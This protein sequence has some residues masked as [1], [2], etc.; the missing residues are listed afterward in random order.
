M[1]WPLLNA[2]ANSA[3]R[4][5]GFGAKAFVGVSNYLQLF[6]TAAV[7]QATIHILIYAAGTA[8]AKIVLAFALAL[9]V[10]RAFRGV[11]LVRSVLFIPVLMSFVAVGVLW[12]FVLNPN[13]GLLNQALGALGLPD[14][15][16]WLGQSETA[17]ASIMMVDVWKW[18]GYHVIL[19]VAGLQA[20]RADLYEAA[21]VDGANRFQLFSH[22]TLP[23]MRT[24]VGLNFIIAIGGAL[25][26]FDL[27]Y[28]MTKGGPYGSS[29]TLMTLM[30]R[31]AFAEQHYGPASALAVL[32][33][34]G[35]ALVTL[36]QLRRLRS[37]YT[38]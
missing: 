12:S 22:V 20:V 26:V 13:Q 5:N 25:N 21:R 28:V 18:L 37:D 15:I 38:N 30:Y 7:G 34:A 17:L 24:M 14:N 6:R 2:F 10:G 33:F 32:L 1:L 11:A 9:L 16:A 19:F 8:V 4:W 3:F 23:A 36:V 35:V 29:E 31:M 27:V